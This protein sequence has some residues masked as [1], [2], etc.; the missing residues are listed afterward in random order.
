[1]R[2]AWLVYLSC[3]GATHTDLCV[4]LTSCCEPLVPCTHTRVNYSSVKAVTDEWHSSL[5]CMG[6]QTR[7]CCQQVFSFLLYSLNHELVKLTGKLQPWYIE[8]SSTFFL[9]CKWTRFGE[10]D[11]DSFVLFPPKTCTFFIKTFYKWCLSWINDFL[12][13][14]LTSRQ[15]K[16]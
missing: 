15:F 13:N 2:C 4:A 14:W 3:L 9:H 10:V 11:T 7:M 12:Y 1:M 6:T 5:A 16:M 8:N